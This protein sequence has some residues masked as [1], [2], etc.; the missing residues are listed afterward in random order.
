MKKKKSRNGLIFLA[1]VVVM[2]LAFYFYIANHTG[3]DTE[4]DEEYTVAQELL[5]RDLSRNYPATP[6]EVVKLYTEITQCFYTGD[7]T[8]EELDAL[9]LL[10]YELFDE[11]LK[12]ANPYSFYSD[13]VKNEIEDYSE[14]SYTISAYS[15]SSSVD[16][17]KTKFEKDGFTW[18]N[19]YVYLTMRRA[20]QITRVEEVFV[21]RKDA[22]G[23]WKIYGWQ[24]VE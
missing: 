2:V 9:I 4:S 6:K 17:E 12:E 10:S 5:L 22:V 18:T 11:E 21:L 24:L 16:I 15:T 1:I 7:Y 23:D 3:D 8:E 13:G 14:K 19:V 20:T